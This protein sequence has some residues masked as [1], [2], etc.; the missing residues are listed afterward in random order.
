[1]VYNLYK[2]L[3]VGKFCFFF[4]NFFCHCGECVS[5]LCVILRACVGVIANCLVLPSIFVL[6]ILCLEMC[7]RSFVSRMERLGGRAENP[8]APNHSRLDWRHCCLTFFLSFS[9]LPDC[10]LH[11]LFPPID[12]FCLDLIPSSATI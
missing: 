3:K 8:V 1:M 11:F 5:Q 7:R 10:F 12:E 2:G 6:Y 4:F 9:P